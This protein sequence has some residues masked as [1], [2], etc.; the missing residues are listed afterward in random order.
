M[1]ERPWVTPR[2]PLS[3]MEREVVQEQ[4]EHG[5]GAPGDLRLGVLR[6]Q[7]EGLDVFLVVDVGVPLGEP[8]LGLL[9]EPLLDPLATALFVGSRP[10]GR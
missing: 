2:L 8:E 7:G 3:L 6:Q 10:S 9:V 4:V 5:C 1:Y